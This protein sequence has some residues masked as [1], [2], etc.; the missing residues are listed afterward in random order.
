M[1]Y[2]VIEM[3]KRTGLTRQTIYN[4]E[5]ELVEKGLAERTEID[6]KTHSSSK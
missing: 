5:K 2:K 1:E 6:R 4:H 3:S